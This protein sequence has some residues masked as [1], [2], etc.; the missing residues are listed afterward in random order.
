MTKQQFTEYIAENPKGFGIWAM[1][2]ELAIKDC[3][4]DLYVQHW[5]DQYLDPGSRGNVVRTLGEDLTN[6]LIK[7]IN[8]DNE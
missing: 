5:I 4:F 6:A 8:Q 1:A 2:A 7:I 3:N